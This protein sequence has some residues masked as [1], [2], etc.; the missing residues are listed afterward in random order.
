MGKKEILKLAV[1]YVLVFFIALY[2]DS[3]G[4][5]LKNGNFIYR[6]KS[7]GETREV[8]LFLDVENVLEKYKVDLEIEPRRMTKEE[9]EECFSKA[10]EKIDRDMLS[11]EKV[12][13][14]QDRYEDGLVTAEWSFLPAGII[15]A[16]GTI[17]SE[18]VSKD[19]VLVTATVIL[20]CDSYEK[21]YRFPIQIKKPQMSVEE[22][23]T[24]E[25][26]EWVESQQTLEGKEE[27][28]LPS[29]LGGSP[30]VWTEKKEYLSLKILFLEGLSAVF[31]LFASKKEKEDAVKRC[32]QLRELQYPEIVNQLLILI[33]AGMT[34][35]QA[36]HRIAYQYMEIR[37]QEI[38]EVSEVYE[39]ILQ[40]DRRLTEG[41]NE[42]IAYENFG[43]QMDAMCYRRLM[44]L[45]VQNLE[46]GSRDICQ[47]LNLEAKQA[48]EQRVLL[49]KRLGEEASTKMML[50]MMIMMV[51]VMAIVMAPAII[52]FSV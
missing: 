20:E 35:R 11:I 32:R 21:V 50:P 37:K 7:G 46:K 47:H 12:V 24:T 33:E 49:A 13:S 44:R 14:V 48:Y 30:A 6:D 27:F 19:G 31:L 36:W 38:I 23:I 18:N 39:A 41:E 28:Q 17:Q 25:I 22:K 34:T 26:S 51:L 42:R 4:G 29:E 5:I 2:M 3:Q 1:A 40:M 9:A 15:A 52:S 43:T 10:M 45:F 8:E 16:D